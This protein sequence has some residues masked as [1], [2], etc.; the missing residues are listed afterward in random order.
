MQIFFATY[1]KIKIRVA[2]YFSETFKK[3]NNERGLVPIV[4]VGLGSLA[5]IAWAWIEVGDFKSAI[6]IGI[7]NLLYAMSFGIAGYTADITGNVITS[8]IDRKITTDPI[9]IQGWSRT[10]DLGNMVIALG[11]VVVGIATA[12]R[13]REYEAKKL[14]FPLIAIALLINFSP[15]LVGVIVDASNILYVEINPE[16]ATSSLSGIVNNINTTAVGE[17]GITRE[18][19]TFWRS[20]APGDPGFHCETIQETPTVVGQLNEEL[21]KKN[22]VAFAAQT[23]LYVGLFILSAFVFFYISFVFISRYCYLSIIFVLAPLAFVAYIFPPTKKYFSMW[24]EKLIQWAFI[25]TGGM[26]FL[27]LGLNILKNKDF[28]GGN[29]IWALV[30]TLLYFYIS[31]SFVKK[32]SGPVAGAVLGLATGAAGLAMGAVVGGAT[33]AAKGTGL[34]G[35]AQ[36]GA[37]AAQYGA[38]SLAERYTPFVAPG[39]ANLRREQQQKADK[40]AERAATWTGDQ[41]RNLATGAAGTTRQRNDKIEA[42]KQMS[43]KGELGALSLADRQAAVEYASRRGTSVSA[44]SKGDYRA[45]EFDTDRVSALGGGAVGARRARAEQ[46]ETNLPRMSGE[47]RRNID[48]RDITPELIT[49]PAMNT[50]ILRDFRTADDSRIGSFGTRGTGASGTPG[51]INGAVNTALN[52]AETRARSANDVNEERR[53]ASIRTEIMRTLQAP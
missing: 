34:A 40:S 25:G 27:S 24:W 3:D 1:L 22:P 51:A 28:G 33:M 43:E 50:N 48:T 35:L 30:V 52:D 53:L 21:A 32:N 49:S 45:A 39:T 18:E 41:R 38:T 5:A 8:I 9:F 23:S 12:L 29:A 6:I 14:L 16:I 26:F 13:L 15:L 46:L 37:Q 31:L 2:N 7:P 17:A 11:F 19:C 10:R 36:R 44:L 42:I 4:L 20:T 47:Q